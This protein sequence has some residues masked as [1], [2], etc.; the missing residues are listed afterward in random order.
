MAP[1]DA[2]RPAAHGDDDHDETTSVDGA[3]QPTPDAAAQRARALRAAPQAIDDLAKL[4]VASVDR[5]IGVQLDYGPETLS[6]LDHYVRQ[7]AT[8]EAREGRHAALDLA[9]RTVGAYFGEVLRRR[10]SAWWHP[11][12]DDVAGWQLRFEDVFLTVSPY[13]LACT[14]LG[15][16]EPDGIM[17]AGIVIEEEEL[18]DI[19]EHLAR[20]PLVTEEEFVAPSTR[21]DVL[22][23]VVDQLKGRAHA[24]G[25]GDVGYDDADYEG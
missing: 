18:D 13:A 21:F 15:L 16:L 25:L 6:I 9:A 8:T 4:C 3:A 10:F 24:R 22:E 2:P 20:L 23:I 7:A 1:D 5:A 14:A 12:G 11:V 19:A 17:E